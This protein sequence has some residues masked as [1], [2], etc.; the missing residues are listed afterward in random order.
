MYQGE[1]LPTQYLS[2]PVFAPHINE[3]SIMV[4]ISWTV[5]LVVSPNA[6]DPD[7]YTNN[8]IED[9]FSPHSMKYNFSKKG[10]TPHTINLLDGS[11]TALAKELIDNGYKKSA[12]PIS[13]PAKTTWDENDLR[14]VE[15]KWDTVIRK[16]VRMRSSSLFS[17]TLTLHAMGRNGYE[18]KP[19][20]YNV[21]ITINAP[22]YKGNLYDAILQTYRNLSPIEIRAE[23]RIIV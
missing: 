6:N 4:E 20:A 15:L 14:V 19:I 13:H 16:S 3:M 5:A 9:V 12:L 23:S 21:V 8:C 10:E 22:R 1:I 17:P 18:S 7:A 2:L 11:K